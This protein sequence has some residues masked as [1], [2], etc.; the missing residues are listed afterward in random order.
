L[1]VVT[2]ILWIASSQVAAQS[3]PACTDIVNQATA[4]YTIGAEEFTRDSNATSTL[5]AQLLDV[6]VVWQDVA[7]ITVSPGDAGKVLTFLVTNTGNATDSYLL[8]GMSVL[9]D[10]DF[11]PILGDIYLDSNGS[12]TYEPGTDEFYVAG[13][14]DPVLGAGES[15]VVFLLNDIP[16]DLDDGDEG[17]S[18]LTATSNI[19]SGDPGTVIPEAT[20]CDADAV[21]GTSGGSSSDI[22]TYIVSNVVVDVIKSALVSDQFGGTQPIPGATITYTISVTFSGSGTAEGV[23]ITDVIPA[24][25]TYTAGSLT[26][27]GASL[28]DPLD[29]DAGDVGGTTPGVVTVS[30]G[31]VSA[32]SA[33]QVIVFS[34][35]IN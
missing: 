6:S 16:P 5:V 15:I 19:G 9:P 18:R 14:N 32:G 2:A 28:T 34:V 10:D 22:G 27:N 1:G 13:S 7:S 35:V 31:D 23:V 26:L 12:G 11:N 17:D 30:L 29:G 4:T 33:D 24:N 21:I 8:E 25:T 20:E 3:T